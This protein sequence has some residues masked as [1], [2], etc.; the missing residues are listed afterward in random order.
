MGPARHTTAHHL[1]LPD[2][3]GSGAFSEPLLRSMLTWLRWLLLAAVLALSVVAPTAGRLGLTATDLV[4]LFAGYSALI[5]AC[6]R[7]IGWLA[8][9]LVVLAL[10]TAVVLTTIGFCGSVQCPL[11]FLSPLLI[12]PLPLLLTTP[13]ALVA[14]A[15][16]AASISVLTLAQPD[17]D[18]TPAAL[19]LL[20]FENVLLLAFTAPVAVLARYLR[21]KQR[22]VEYERTIIARLRL[23]HE[24]LATVSISLDPA[25]IG[26][27]LAELAR[28]VVGGDLGLVALLREDRTVGDVWA[29]LPI[30][31]HLAERSDL[32]VV[33]T[34]GTAGEALVLYD[35]CTG[36]GYG[37][38]EALG[39]R[40]C[41]AIPLQAEGTLVGVLLVGS[42][43]PGVYREEARDWLGTIA[44]QAALSIEHARR[45]TRERAY[46]ARLATLERTKSDFLLAASHELR[47]PLAAMKITVGLLREQ[48]AGGDPARGHLLASLGRNTERLERLVDEILDMARLQTGALRLDWV[49]LDPHQLVHDVATA[50]APL[51]EARGQ[52]LALRFGSPLPCI[53]GDRRRIEQVLTNLLANANQYSGPG[54]RIHLAAEAHA[55]GVLLQVQDQGPGIPPEYHQ[56]IFEP[57]QRLSGGSDAQRGIGLGLAI[58]RAIV[59]LHGGRIWVES[60][61]GQGSTF[62]VFLPQTDNF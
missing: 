38:Y 15:G 42:R 20:V 23:L 35:T 31:P 27:T 17:W 18:G 48:Q 5:A 26:R 10:D 55:G 54:S 14:T 19:Q 46:T 13:A 37:L 30:D 21:T 39:L 28:Q 2:P 25:R 57:F 52:H 8:L 22:E 53:W 36:P 61:P 47:T 50:L 58:S 32:S 51:L 33:R 6:Q 1:E 56:Q 12:V 59:T 41:V 43:R 4:L 60:A 9:P 29:T 40:S 34:V 44:P 3:P 16:L 45:S 62:F 24:V 49:L 11:Y 7:R